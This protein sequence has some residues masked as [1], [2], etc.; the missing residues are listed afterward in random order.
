MNAYV[1]YIA[2]CN[3]LNFPGHVCKTLGH[4]DHLLTRPPNVY[5]SL[6]SFARSV[7]VIW[8]GSISSDPKS[9]YWEGGML[10]KC[11]STCSWAVCIVDASG[12]LIPLH[13]LRHCLAQD[14]YEQDDASLLHNDALV[15]T[16]QHQSRIKEL[17]RS[18]KIAWQQ[19]LNPLMSI[20]G[21]KPC[22][23]I[24]ISLKFSMDHRYYYRSV[25][26]P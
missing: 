15:T 7:C 6:G 20:V 23:W 9:G 25:N 13:L 18:I 16:W 17:M 1:S 3:S 2:G 22:L 19:C 5:T 21:S 8:S 11:S 10:S 24:G 12:L 14:K 4:S 26:S